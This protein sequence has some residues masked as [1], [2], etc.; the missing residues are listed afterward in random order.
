MVKYFTK[1]CDS[2][3]KFWFLTKMWIFDWNLDF[4]PKF[5]LLIETWIFDQNIDF[6]PKYWFLTK[7]LIFDQNF[8]FWPKFL[9]WT[10][11]F[12]FDQ[13]W[14]IF[15]RNFH[16][17]PILRLSTDNCN[18]W[19]KFW[20]LTEIIIFDRNFNFWLL[21]K[22]CTSGR[23]FNWPKFRYFGQIVQLYA[24][25]QMITESHFFVQLF[26]PKNLSG[27][28]VINLGTNYEKL[29]KLQKSYKNRDLPRPVLK[30]NSSIF[31]DLSL[32]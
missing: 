13:N 23:N 2:W 29:Q 6:L 28:H 10:K 1:K 30:A 16:F 27:M 31:F 11:L 20:F 18:L 24:W 8:D 5:G 4:W 22:I 17:W 3:P 19:V 14:K 9:C 12:I 21:T 7:I 32:I 15:D 26:S 25:V